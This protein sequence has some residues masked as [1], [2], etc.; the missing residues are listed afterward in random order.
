MA[1]VSR[2]LFLF[3]FI[4][5][6]AARADAPLFSSEDTIV[7]TIRA[8]MRELIRSKHRKEEY[9]AEVRYVDAAGNEITLAARI[10][11]RGN[12][13]LATCDFPPIRLEF[14]PGSTGGT[15]FEEQRRLKVVTDCKRGRDGERWLLQEYGI[16]RAYNVITD[17]SYRVRKMAVTWQD[18]ESGRWERTAPAFVIEETEALAGRVGRHEIRP[19]A[20]RTEQFELVETTN[21]L[22]FQYLI[23]NTDFSVTRGSKGEGCCHNASV[24]AEPGSQE[25]WIVIPY[26]FDQAGIIDTDYALPDRRLGIRQVTQR[27]YRGFCWQN[28]QLQEAIQLFNDRRD[29][30]TATLVP[31]EFPESRQNRIRRYLD[32]FYDTVNDPEELQEEI[33]AKC[34]GRATFEVRETRTVER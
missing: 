26:D 20:V 24:I 12:A 32:R 15:L 1:M 4:A 18:S 10:S 2:I 13:R 23:A 5:A 30:I 28:D 33:I 29:A 34:R 27:L 3:I 17:Y 14:D 9:P 19:P 8:P 6:A 7:A 22:L 31:A 21:H 25:N 16:Y 11:A